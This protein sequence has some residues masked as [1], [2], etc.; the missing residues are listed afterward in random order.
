MLRS[1]AAATVVGLLADV[2]VFWQ[3][4]NREALLQ[5]APAPAAGGGG[6]VGAQ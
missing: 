2:D 4:E 5:Q 6:D 3:W 1:G